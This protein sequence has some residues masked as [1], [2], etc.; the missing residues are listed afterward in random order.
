MTIGPVIL[1]HGSRTD[2]YALDFLEVVEVLP[3]QREQSMLADGVSHK[4]IL[5]LFGGDIEVLLLQFPVEFQH[6]GSDISEPF[7]DIRSFGRAAFDDIR[8]LG[9]LVPQC[10]RNL[11]L[12]RKLDE[13]PVDGDTPHNG[14]AAVC[15]RGGL[16]QVEENF[17][18]A[19]HR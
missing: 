6:P 3:E 12:G 14:H 8:P 11:Q 17:E 7:V 13:L 16:L 4:G 1:L 19:F 18:C 9:L 10:R 15:A 5:H 2:G